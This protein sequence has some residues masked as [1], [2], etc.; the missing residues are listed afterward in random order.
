MR[1]LN[2]SEGGE[3]YGTDRGRVWRQ[4]RYD[5]CRRRGAY[6]TQPVFAGGIKCMREMI[7]E[8]A[9]AVTAATGG[10]LFMALAGTLLFSENGFLVRFV[11]IW[12]SGVMK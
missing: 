3:K 11:E 6:G 8:Y 9:G 5:F 4:Y 10:I 12:G 7:R 1:L 2:I